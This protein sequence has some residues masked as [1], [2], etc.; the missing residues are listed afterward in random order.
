MK[1]LITNIII[2]LC[3]VTLTLAILGV[4]SILSGCTTDKITLPDG[5][6]ILHQKLFY[7]GTA[8]RAEFYYEDP[9]TVI[10]II[11]DDPNSR[12]NPGRLVTPWGMG[13]AE[14]D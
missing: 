11:A 1:T 2:F 8:K 12:V 7:V 4:A 14:N 10:W 13:E 6:E 9:N 3:A 5:T